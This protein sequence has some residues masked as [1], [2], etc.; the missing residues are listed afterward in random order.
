MKKNITILGAGTWGIAL[1]TLLHEND[2]K[3]TL[4]AHRKITCENVKKGVNKLGLKLKEPIVITN[5]LEEACENN[6]I[7]I[8]IPSIY[9]KETLLKIKPL[10]K[11]G[12]IIINASKGIEVEEGRI[13]SEVIKD[14]LE[15]CETA[16]LSGP[17]HAEE[18]AKKLPAACVLASENEELAKN[19]QN[20]F[21][22]DYFRIYTNKDVV[23]V[24]L[25]GAA[26]NVIAIAAGIIEG[27][28]DGDNAKAALMTR[29]INEISELGMKMGGKK[30]TFYGLAGIGD[31]IVTCTSLHSRNCRAGILLGSGK[32]LSETLEKIGMVVEGVNSTKALVLLAKKYGV[33]MPITKEVEKVL[34]HGKDPKDSV[35]DL[36][37][38][39][40]IS[41]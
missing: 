29:G 36:M 21:M 37:R 28:K 34:W 4:Y 14:I 7:I 15:E 22:N 16:V 31:M 39:D 12:T 41:E 11:K 23:G 13:F 24:E 19:L 30:E 9:I 3:V 17:V 6:I 40:K 20:I 32:N 8:A 27:L 35:K 26:K 1:S 18:L 33:E 2:H 10:V 25:S 5:D 38:R